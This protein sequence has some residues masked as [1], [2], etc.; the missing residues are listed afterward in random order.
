MVKGLLHFHGVVAQI[1]TTSN[2]FC[3][4]QQTKRTKHLT[5][6]MLVI[7]SLINNT[8]LNNVTSRNTSLHYRSV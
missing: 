3:Q 8:L 5:Q 6:Q 7:G 4:Q 2:I 1:Q